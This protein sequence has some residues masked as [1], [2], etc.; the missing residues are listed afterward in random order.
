[1]VYNIDLKTDDY[2]LIQAVKTKGVKPNRELPE[3]VVLPFREVAF[4]DRKHVTLTLCIKDLQYFIDIFKYLARHGYTVENVHHS[5]DFN[6]FQQKIL[7][8]PNIQR[9]YTGI[10]VFDLSGYLYVKGVLKGNGYWHLLDKVF[11]VGLGGVVLYTYSELV[12]LVF[13]LFPEHLQ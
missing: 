3:V 1:M 13:L 10:E 2:P 6:M 9:Q 5:T 12:A 11:S 4:I 8:V 7:S